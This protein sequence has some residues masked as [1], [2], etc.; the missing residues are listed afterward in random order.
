M[1]DVSVTKEEEN[2]NAVCD[3]VVATS[4]EDKQGLTAHPEAR[5][6]ERKS[7]Y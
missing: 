7:R 3:L 2:E 4:W 6:K 1:I 5:G